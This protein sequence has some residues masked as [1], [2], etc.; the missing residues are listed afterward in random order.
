LIWFG[1]IPSANF[2][3]LFLQVDAVKRLNFTTP[4]E[5]GGPLL[6]RFVDVYEQVTQTVAL[7][8]ESYALKSI[9]G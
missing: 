4:H 1:N 5:R 6:E 8:V 2:S 7:P 3:F 9:D